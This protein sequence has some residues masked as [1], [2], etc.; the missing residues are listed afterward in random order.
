MSLAQ[1]SLDLFWVQANPGREIAVDALGLASQAD[2]IADALLPKMSVLTRRARYLS[3]LCS[4][5]KK[6]HSL[7]ELYRR[8]GLLALA[9]ARVLESDPQHHEL[10]PAV[11]GRRSTVEARATGRVSNA[12]RLY[13][14]RAFPDYRA[15]MRNL[16]LI[17]SGTFPK[18]LPEGERLARAYAHHSRPSQCLCEISSKERTIIKQLLGFDER[19]TPD[20]FR[21]CRRD[22][23]R[24]LEP[25]IALHARNGVIYPGQ[26]LAHFRDRPKRDR[27]GAR[28]SLH[29][30]YVWELASLA[31][32]LT[33][34]IL[35]KRLHTDAD[36]NGVASEL[37]RALRSS[38]HSP[39]LEFALS[40]DD[41]AARNVVGLA[42]EACRRYKEEMGFDPRPWWLLRML[43]RDGDAKQFV[44]SVLARHNS[45]K[46]GDAWIRLGANDR[47]IE[48]LAASAKLLPTGAEV[49]SYR[50]RALS[51][52][53]RDLG[54]YR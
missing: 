31:L 11:V 17:G 14:R 15:L 25:Y 28:G 51:D 46:G 47:R 33:F 3:F 45:I 10:C 29:K 39:G 16:G 48:R 34:A 40:A 2:R 42:R 13:K 26:L 43:V 20:V 50:L 18:L 1:R 9:A 22:T 27:D 7:P 35:A 49:R 5:R 8:E 23:F 12:E 36:S 41:D 32:D 44:R 37:G 38:S 54:M 21:L 24:T 4:A 53:A 30:A 52:L 19:A 6:S